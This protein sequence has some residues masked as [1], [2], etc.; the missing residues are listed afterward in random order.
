MSK[1]KIKMVALMTLPAVEGRKAV[2]AGASFEAL[3]EQEV[4]DL[5][6]SGRAV[7]EVQAASA[8]SPAK[9]G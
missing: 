5:E 8:G 6:Q 3:N 7:K 9:G 1:I 4:R 2:S